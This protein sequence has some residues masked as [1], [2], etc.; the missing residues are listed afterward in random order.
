MHDGKEILQN[1]LKLY[2]GKKSEIIKLFRKSDTFKAGVSAIL[3][4]N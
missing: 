2:D 4:R 1:L 3:I